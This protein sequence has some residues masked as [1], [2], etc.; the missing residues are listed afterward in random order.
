MERK[1][2]T[3]AG[4]TRPRQTEE[5]SLFDA[6]PKS[7]QSPKESHSSDEVKR[8]ETKPKPLTFTIRDIDPKLIEL[9]KNLA[10][11]RKVK[12]DI[13]TNQSSITVEAIEF[14]FKNLKEEIIER[15]DA[16]KEVERKRGT[17]K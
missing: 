16:I 4:P 8:K 15:P 9:I 2:M 12:G 1:K 7:F 17:R 5:D 6:A 3:G 13:M 14:F 11:T 10:Y